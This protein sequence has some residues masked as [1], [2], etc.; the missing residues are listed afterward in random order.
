MPLGIR[1]HTEGRAPRRAQTG[2][3]EYSLPTLHGKNRSTSA[4]ALPTLRIFLIHSQVE[5]AH[6]SFSVVLPSLQQWLYSLLAGMAQT[7]MIR[8]FL[9]CFYPIFGCV[10]PVKKR[11]ISEKTCANKPVAKVRAVTRVASSRKQGWIV[12]KVCFGKREKT[13]DFSKSLNLTLAS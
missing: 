9:Q 4:F 3:P 2:N 12:T 6:S 10:A 11:N 1:G 5:T 7:K 13:P 8:I